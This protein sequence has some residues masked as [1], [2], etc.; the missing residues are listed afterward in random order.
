M[1][2]D[3]IKSVTKKEGMTLTLDSEILKE[4]NNKNIKEMK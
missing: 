4:L 2:E 1:I 3:A